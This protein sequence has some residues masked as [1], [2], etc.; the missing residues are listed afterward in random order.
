MKLDAPLSPGNPSLAATAFDTIL[1]QLIVRPDDAG[2]DS[3]A[4]LIDLIR[5]TRLSALDAS[6]NAIRSLTFLLS[7]RPDYRQALRNHLMTVIGSRRQLQLYTDSGIL[8]NE[9]IWSAFR[10]RLGAK[11]LPAEYRDG[12]LKDVLGKL[13][14]RQDDYEWVAALPDAV[15][16]DL[17]QV[18]EIDEHAPAIHTRNSR[19]EMLEAAQVLSYRIAAIGLEPEL[20]RNHPAIE[21]FESPFLTQNVVLRDYLEQYKARLFDPAQ[22]HEDDRHVRVLLDQCEDVVR[23]VR[24]TA[25]REGVSVSLTYLM[26]RLRQHLDRLRLLLDLLDPEG[27]ADLPQRSL[28]LFKTLVEAENRRT[29]LVDLFTTNTDLLALQVT[30]HAGR[31]GEHY[32]ASNRGEWLQMGRSAMGAGFI[33]GFMALVKILLAKLKLAPLIEAFAFS[34]NYSLGFMLVHILHFTIATKQPAMTAAAIAASMEQHDKG[35][36]D[37]LDG[38]AELIEAVARTQFVAIL[39]NVLVAIP[40]ALLIAVSVKYGLG[41]VW[42]SPEKARHLLHDLDPIH[43]LALPHAAIAGICLFLAGLISGYYDNQAIY[44]RVPARLQQL[45]WPRRLLG[46]ARWSRVC[47][48]VENN[49]GALAGNFFFGIMLGSIGTIGFLL[50]LPIDIRH[51]TFSSANLAYAAVALDFQLPWQTWLLSVAGIALIGATNLAVSFGLALFVALRARR[52]SF[53]RSRALL[54][55]LASRFM[56]GPRRFFVA[57]AEE[58]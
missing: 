50:G 41:E 35:R 27:V 3:L 24:K 42:I 53:T 36:G 58:S 26:V 45:R 48:Y 56:R 49:L 16:L 2:T 7:Q 25:A 19:L 30:E 18:L 22:A 32:I 46:E 52:T 34:M 13:F 37:A 21:Q 5:P 12:Y 38:L 33:V 4:R 15:W 44:N 11:L 47:A 9:G 1:D 31:T 14:D 17:W 43:S 8:S 51:I 54:G 57:P 10:N 40:T 20:V 39:G 55:K 29:S 6:I 23:K 28:A